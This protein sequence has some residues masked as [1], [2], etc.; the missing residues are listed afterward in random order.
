[1]RKSKLTV[2]I[3]VA[4]VLT[5]GL[6]I[7]CATNIPISSSINDFVMMGLRTNRQDSVTL[8]I[9][10]NI[11]DGET[12]VMNRDG[13]GRT[14]RVLTD[15]G[16]ILKRM[17]NDYMTAKFYRLSESGDIKITIRLNEFTVQDYSVE[18]AGMAVLRTLLVGARTRHPRMV[19]VRIT[20]SIDIAG[21][22]IEETR[23][24]IS[25]SEE[26]YT[27]QFATAVGNRAFATAVNDAN[28]RLLMQ[29]G[30]FFDEIGL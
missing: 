24:F 19:S 1:M 12:E 20:A 5:I 2:G 16:T 28:N 26:H 4:L 7:G 18:T 8:E 21:E 6:F 14:G 22:N 3:L 13:T 23:N 11:H 30:A 9:I 27:G 10:S 29:M 17:V 25:S 15:Q